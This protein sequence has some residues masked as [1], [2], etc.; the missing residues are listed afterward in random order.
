MKIMGFAQLRNELSKGNLHNFFK[1]MEA[2][3]GCYVFDQASDDGSIDVYNQIKNL[4]VLACDRNDFSN[5]I[6]CKSILLNKLLHDHPD[7]DWIFWLDGDTLIDGRLLENKGHHLRE[8][9]KAASE[10]DYDAIAMGHYNL[11]R[12]DIHYRQDAN[13]HDLHGKVIPLWRNNKKLQFPDQT[14]LHQTQYPNGIS[15]IG[16]CSFNLIHRGFATDY[17]I[18]TKYDVYKERGQ[19]GW[20]LDRLLHE[21]TLTVERIPYGI[22]PQWFELTDVQNPTRKRKIKEIYNEMHGIV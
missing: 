5:E 17:Q 13:Y 1:C 15:N 4:C 3:D 2:L 7:T 9:C 6:K 10:K 18:M 14:G 8:L 11:W 19:A 20:S 22:I 21:E 12:S 16:G